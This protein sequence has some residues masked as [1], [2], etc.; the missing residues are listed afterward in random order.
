[1]DSKQIE[2]NLDERQEMINKI[3]AA[4]L[5]TLSCHL[6]D[7]SAPEKKLLDKFVMADFMTILA[8]WPHLNEQIKF[9][10]FKTHL[11]AFEIFM[12]EA[13]KGKV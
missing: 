9:H 11:S 1:M 13:V 4:G 10:V 5:N 2:Q 8:C 12:K 7:E 3:I 6:K